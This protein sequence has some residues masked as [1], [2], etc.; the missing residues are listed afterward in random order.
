MHHRP[1]RLMVSLFVLNLTATRS[2]K[3]VAKS[4]VV[5]FFTISISGMFERWTSSRSLVSYGRVSGNYYAEP[6][7]TSLL[8]AP[9][10]PPPSSL[11]EISSSSSSSSSISSSGTTFLAF[12]REWPWGFSGASSELLDS[13][14]DAGRFPFLLVFLGWAFLEE[15]FALLVALGAYLCCGTSFFAMVKII[16]CLYSFFS[17]ILPACLFTFGWPLPFPFYPVVESESL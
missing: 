15:P 17:N 5:S 11:S 8:S 2:E 3:M 1:F 4:R 10:V 13:S 12:L 7:L 9:S 16:V 14:S 6:V